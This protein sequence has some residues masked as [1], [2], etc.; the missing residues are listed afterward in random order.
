[1]V[2]YFC[3]AGGFTCGALSA[4]AIVA[5]G[6]DWDERARA[7]YVENNHNSAG[8]PVP[9][10]HAK[11]EDLKPRV[12]R[13]YL[14]SYRG[15][16]TVFVGCPPCQPYTNL[17]TTKQDSSLSQNA[18]RGFVDHVQA[19]HPDFIIVENVPGIRAQKY[20]LLWDESVKRLTDSGYQVRCGVVNAARYGV[21]QKRLRALLVGCKANFGSVPWPE[22]T[23]APDAYRTV[24]DAFDEVELCRLEAG[25]ACAS[26]PLHSASAL[27]A[28]NLRRI[29][30]IRKPGGGRTEWPKSL[31]LQCYNDH[32]GHTDVYGRM[33]WKRPAPTLT[34]RFVS[35]SNGR[36]GHPVEHRAITPREGALL[37]TFPP[38]YKFLHP[39]R[40]V[41]VIHIGN[42][43]PP[44]LARAFVGAIE[45]RL[46]EPHG[47]E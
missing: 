14:A 7:T 28:L 46:A 15:H 47:A 12:I 35:L 25:Q 40:D 18:L 38:D 33:A 29:R 44:R 2:D 41:R 13:E 39:T 9:F 43:V 5:C 23:H 16:P 37:Q 19:L 6:I 21:P 32:V 45:S 27:S 36:F 1:M 22:E 34:T 8:R 11:V 3:G 10:I 20:G 4:G 31:W 42:A 17:R 26:D 24:R 30:A